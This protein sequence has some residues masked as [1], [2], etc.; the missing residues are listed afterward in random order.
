MKTAILLAALIA[1]N[2]CAAD[3]ADAPGAAI[4]AA[5]QVLRAQNPGTPAEAQPA[6]PQAAQVQP[7]AAPAQTTPAPQADKPA[8]TA[9]SAAPGSAASL[10]QVVFGLIVVLGLLVAA[11]WALKRF[12]GMRLHAGAPLKIV[13]GIPVGNRER[14]LVLEVGDQWLVVGVAPGRVSMLTTMPR[15]EQPAG[16][17]QGTAP[18]F[19]AWLKQTLEKRNVK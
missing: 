1:G 14:V 6:A 17:P 8:V 5:A 13:G 12:G 3:V 7:Q 9:A 4:G 16:N 19:G 18:D 11:L 15:G 2:A 10:L